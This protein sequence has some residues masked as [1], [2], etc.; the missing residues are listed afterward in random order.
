MDGSSLLIENIFTVLDIYYPEPKK[1]NHEVTW[2]LLNRFIAY[3]MCC[4]DTRTMTPFYSVYYTTVK[5]AR[6]LKRESVAN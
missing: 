6:H 4:C 5:K 1:R 3:V 2:Y